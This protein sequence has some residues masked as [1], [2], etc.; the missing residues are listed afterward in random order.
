MKVRFSSI[1]SVTELLKIAVLVLL[2]LERAT[3]LGALPLGSVH[4]QLNLPSPITVQERVMLGLGL[5]SAM[6]VM[7]GAV[8]GLASTRG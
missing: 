8:V 6:V 2:T 5:T 3:A 4:I 7:K 1:V